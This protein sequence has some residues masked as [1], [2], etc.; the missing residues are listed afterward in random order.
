MLHPKCSMFISV[1]SNKQG[2]LK[3]Y[4]NIYTHSSRSLLFYTNDH[5]FITSV[6]GE[7]Q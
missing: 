4:T 3:I 6:T 5:D 1:T 7:Q 2:S